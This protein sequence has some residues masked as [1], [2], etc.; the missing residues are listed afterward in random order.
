MIRYD[1]TPGGNVT[2]EDFYSEAR[3]CGFITEQA[4]ERQPQLMLPELNGGFLP[5]PW[6]RLSEPVN[7]EQNRC[8]CL[9]RPKTI[10]D[11][12]RQFPLRFKCHVEAE[13]SYLV[14]VTLRSEEQL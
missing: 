1:F 14:R 11:E 7:I 9:I 12:K 10:P 3:G 4:M 8:G 13:G 6:Y 2:P 5:V